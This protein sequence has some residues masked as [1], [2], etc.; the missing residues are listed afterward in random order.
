MKS[1]TI[2]MPTSH[3]FLLLQLLPPR[4]QQTLLDPHLKKFSASGIKRIAAKEYSEMS[5][6][7]I[8]VSPQPLRTGTPVIPSNGGEPD[9]LHFHVSIYLL[10]IFCASQ[11]GFYC[12]SSLPIADLIFKGSAVAVER[13][14]SSGRDTISLR[15]ASLKADTIRTLMLVKARLRLARAAVNEVL[16]DE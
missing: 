6:W 8:S 15:R 16:G 2:T 12:E 11:V 13:V 14:F 7:N 1:I 9:A 10:A 5:W 4:L 3:P